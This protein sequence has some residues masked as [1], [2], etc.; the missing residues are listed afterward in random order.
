M[1]ITPLIEGRMYS[2]PEYIS[3]STAKI[4]HKSKKIFLLLI[5]K[6]TLLT[7]FFSSDAK[8][9]D[10][11]SRT[12]EPVNIPGIL[13]SGVILLLLIIIYSVLVKKTD[14]A[15]CRNC[16]CSAIGRKPCDE[17]AEKLFKDLNKEVAENVEV[18][19]NENYTVKTSAP[20]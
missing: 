16:L 4:L 9:S 3:D 2:M 12:S 18:D 8:A 5:T 14:T 6:I 10:N 7:L 17:D 19:L 11:L 1:S 13:I 20:L 15:A